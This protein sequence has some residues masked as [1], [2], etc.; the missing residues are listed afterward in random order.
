M[1]K[2]DVLVTIVTPSYNQGQFIEDTI[3]SVL[4]QTYK[5]IQ[6]IVVDG[7]S[8]DN[9]MEVVE[10]YRDK[11]DIII[12]EKDKGQTDA[13]NKGFKLA[14]GELVGWINSDDMLYPYCVE[15]IVK[16]YKQNP[17]GA[18]YYGS[19]LEA[20]DSNNNHIKFR[21]NNMESRQRLLRKDYDVLQPGSF[22]KKNILEKVNYL[23][24]S[25]HY[26]MDLDLFLKLLEHGTLHSVDDKPLAKFRKWEEAKSATG[27]T[28]FIKNIRERLYLH[29]AKFY[30]KSILTT[31]YWQTRFTLTDIVKALFRIK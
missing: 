29:G 1:E 20:I 27:R 6:Y 10:R 12:S 4:N 19:K 28:K 24:E 21:I 9:T 7:A 30:D 23:D 13:I 25:I 2:E 8:T 3:T 31:Y 5:N 18:I 11:I 26:C 22:Y 14:K 15:E 17:E 16:L